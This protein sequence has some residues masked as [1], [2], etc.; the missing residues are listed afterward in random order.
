[1]IIYDYHWKFMIIYNPTCKLYVDK[2]MLWYIN[3]IYIKNC[4]ETILRQKLIEKL[5]VQ[6]PKLKVT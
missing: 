4:E 1:M 5:K 3:N 6:S 2:F